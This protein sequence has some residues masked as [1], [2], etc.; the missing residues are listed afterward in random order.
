MKCN[1][2]SIRYVYKINKQSNGTMNKLLLATA[3]GAMIMTMSC[4]QVSNLGNAPQITKTTT[5]KSVNELDVSRGLNVTY[6]Q[7]DSLIVRVNAP[8]DVMDLIEITIKDDALNCTTK[9]NLGNCCS[10]IKIEV[11]SPEIISFEASSGSSILI[12]SLSTLQPTEF[13]ANSGATIDVRTMM[14]NTA[15]VEASSGSSININKIK[16]NVI[17]ISTS[18]GSSVN[19]TGV[20]QLVEIETSSGSSVECSQ[21]K[22]KT[23]Y[24]DASSGAAVNC[25][26]VSP[27]SIKQSSGAIV[28]NLK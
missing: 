10:R 18:S 17:E 11:L 16:A 23:G 22:A 6:K 5:I 27:Q 20:C 26:I 13:D 21:L 24:V 25:K 15:D 19:A 4:Q 8:S 3:L 12:P 1:Q 9:K 7:S 2:M 14:A 28:N